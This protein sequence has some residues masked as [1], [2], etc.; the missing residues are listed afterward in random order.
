MSLKEALDAHL[1]RLLDVAG[2]VISYS[3]GAATVSGITA[4]KSRPRFS[5]IDI[6]EGFVIGSKNWEFL[7][8]YS[9]VG[10]EPKLGHTITDSAG[11]EYRVQPSNPTDNPWRWSDGQQ[12]FIRIFVEQQ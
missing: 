10:R 1:A 4:V 11:N 9:D 6:A 12:T 3:D 8:R 5:Q 7:V 2:E